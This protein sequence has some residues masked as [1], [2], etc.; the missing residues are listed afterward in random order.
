[1]H[2][3]KSD[4]TMILLLLK[5]NKDPSVHESKALIGNICILKIEVFFWKKKSSQL[6]KNFKFGNYAKIH[7]KICYVGLENQK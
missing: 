4:L 7:Y 1:M 6:L 2:L 5:K 3:H